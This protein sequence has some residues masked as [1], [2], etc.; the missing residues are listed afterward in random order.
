[1]KINPVTIRD[2]IV[3]FPNSTL[4]KTDLPA[5][6]DRVCA[7]L[8]THNLQEDIAAAYAAGDMFEAARLLNENPAN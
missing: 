3:N 7:E 6:A 5:L 2:L 1:M 4:G 8:S